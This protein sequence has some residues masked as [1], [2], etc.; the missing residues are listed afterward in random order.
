[1][2][3]MINGNIYSCSF[4]DPV[5]VFFKLRPM[6]ISVPIPICYK[7]VRMDHFMQEGLYEV[8]ARP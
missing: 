6:P 1:M 5:H 3:V 8:F 7:Q 4:I 2:E